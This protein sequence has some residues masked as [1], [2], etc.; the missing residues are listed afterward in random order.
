MGALGSLRV[1][2][3]AVASYALLFVAVAH[4]QELPSAHQESATQAQQTSPAPDIS[5]G[6]TGSQL[7][8]SIVAPCWTR[9]ARS[10]REPRCD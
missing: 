3:G 10:Q 9:M 8:S 5:S 6:Q 2:S 1:R 7:D 4:A